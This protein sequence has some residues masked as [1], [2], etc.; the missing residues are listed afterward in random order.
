VSKNPVK[1]SNDPRPNGLRHDS[2]AGHVSGESE[3]VDDRPFT[4]GELQVDILYSPTAHARIRKIALAEA[5]KVPGVVALLTHRDL[6]HNRWGTIFQDQPLLA[7]DVVQ[8]V[9]EPIVVIAAESKEALRAAKRAVKIDFEK[10]NPILTVDEAKALGHFLGFHRKIERGD[11]ESAISRAPHKLQGR[12][13][14]AGQDHFYLESQASVAYPKEGGQVE[15][16]CSSQH[17]TEVQHVVAHA[18][19]LK[20]NDVVCVV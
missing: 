18:L 20:L 19:G 10:L 3:F 6:H 12:I 2:S 5:K 4:D 9:G 15:V 16:H 11:V 14:M 8:F 1:P 17:P 7:E 13:S